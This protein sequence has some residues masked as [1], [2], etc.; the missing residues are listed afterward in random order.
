MIG[1]GIWYER[2]PHNYSNDEFMSPQ[3]HSDF[4][5]NVDCKPPDRDK[6]KLG[7]G[8]YLLKSEWAKRISIVQKVYWEQ[9]G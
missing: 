8:D 4:V 3:V 9:E 2:K 1:Y 6:R 7:K 5:C